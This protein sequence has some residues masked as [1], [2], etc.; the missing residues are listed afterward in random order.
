MNDLIQSYYR[1]EFDI[2]N[3]VKDSERIEDSE[4]VQTVYSY[5]SVRKHLIEFIENNKTNIAGF[6]MSFSFLRTDPSGITELSIEIQNNSV[7]RSYAEE[8]LSDDHSFIVE[9]DNK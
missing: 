6:F 4:S 1:D 5:P 7:L 9:I 8:R 3:R 2:L